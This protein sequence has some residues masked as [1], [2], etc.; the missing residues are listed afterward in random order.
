MNKQVVENL[1]LLIFEKRGPRVAGGAAGGA[2][3]PG[4]RLAS[5]LLSTDADFGYIS[6]DVDS[7]RL[8]D[9][10]QTHL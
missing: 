2:T 1:L 7:W 8:M 10:Q 5:P 6:I 4:P 3:R 9:V